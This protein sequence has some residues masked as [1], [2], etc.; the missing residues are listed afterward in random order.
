MKNKMRPTPLTPA[1]IAELDFTPKDDGC[2]LP[3]DAETVVNVNDCVV[4]ICLRDGSH[5]WFRTDRAEHGML[6]GYRRVGGRWVP[7]SVPVVSVERYY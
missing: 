2:L 7:H 5:F 3:K 4:F 1:Q 6:R